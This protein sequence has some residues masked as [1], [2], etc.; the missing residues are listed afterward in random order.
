[1]A[2]MDTTQPADLITELASADPADAPEPA[3]QLAD[4]LGERLEDETTRPDQTEPGS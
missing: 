3:E 1:M 4:L 2:V